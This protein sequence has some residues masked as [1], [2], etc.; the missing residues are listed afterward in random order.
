MSVCHIGHA[1][2]RV[3]D[4]EASTEFFELIGLQVTS[5]TDDRVQLRAWNDWDHHTLTL[6]R[7]EASALSHCGWRVHGADDL[8]RFADLLDRL[9]TPH[10]LL[11]PGEEEAQGAALR[12]TTPSGLPLELYVGMERYEA[13]PELRSP[14]PSRPQLRPAQVSPRR[15]DHINFFVDDV[16][17][18]QE[19]LTTH[20]G[21]HHRYF[22][23]NAD[24][25]RTGS[26]LSRTNVTHEIALARN[27][28]QN[29]SLLN[30]VAYYVDTPQELL[31]LADLLGERGVPI[32][33]GPG[34]HATS[35]AMFLY[36]FEPSGHR[37]ELWTG[38]YLIFDPD[39]EPRRW[40]AEV[41][42]KGLELWGSTPPAETFY[43]YGTALA[44]E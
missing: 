12:F 11:S 22:M 32:E 40:D 18:E 44:A 34:R 13:P 33:Y 5:R 23:E 39:W 8:T 16:A 41:A 17:A 24:G 1:E 9:G 36:V 43:S 20:L 30:H 27:G 3:V 38:G 37:V 10:R 4:L 15:F 26:W 7:G 28:A 6:A 35:D 21:I 31:N 2:L 14:L 19:W 29:G 42:R 25:V